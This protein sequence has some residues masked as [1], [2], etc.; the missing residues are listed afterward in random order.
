MVKTGSAHELA[1]IKKVLQDHPDGASQSEI[2][3]ASGLTIGWRTLLRRLEILIAGGEV[4]VIKAGRSTRYFLM[5]PPLP[6]NLTNQD[7][8]LPLSAASKSILEQVTKPI[9]H[10]MPVGY[11]REFLENYIPNKDSYLNQEEKNKLAGM[12]KTG[13]PQYPAGT[14][15]RE[16]LSRLLID[17]SWNSSRLEGNTYSLLETE[18]LIAV[19]IAADGKPTIDAQMIL[20]HKDAI[21]FIVNGAEEVDFN[22]YSILSLH[23]LLSDNLLRDPSASGRL[24]NHPVGISKSV[25]TLLAIP[26]LIA[27]MFDMILEKARQINDPFEQVFFTMVQLPYL[28]PFDDV[29]KR[30]SRLAANIPLVKQNLSP[31]S[32]TDVPNDIYINGLLGVYELNRVELLKDVFMWAYQRSAY[33]YAAVRQSVGEPDSFRLKYRSDLRT[34]VNEIVRN[35]YGFEQASKTI[36][37][38]A[39]KISEADRQKF[40]EVVERELLTLHE[41]NFARYYIRPTEYERWKETWQRIDK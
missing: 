12:G 9:E 7:T 30:V 5:K 20:N 2:L 37:A 38:Y 19:G 35:N 21:E 32:F 39:T 11:H 18:R 36:Q 4:S 13:E 27:E 31:L 17:L 10:R 25:F 24:R 16:I 23:A 40:I 6:V 28:Q 26:Q 29:N 22:R 14:Y 41:G 1:A 3:K 33:R 8:P 15:A 34:L